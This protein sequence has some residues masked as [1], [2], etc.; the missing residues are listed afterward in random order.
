MPLVRI[1]VEPEVVVIVDSVAVT[2]VASE[3]SSTE[4]KLLEDVPNLDNSQSY[5]Y[6][7]P[8]LEL[9]TI[10]STE[11]INE[12]LS[13][14]SVQ[15]DSLGFEMLTRDNVQTT[16]VTPASV[17]SEETIQKW[18][19]DIEPERIVVEDSEAF[20]VSELGD[21]EESVKSQSQ[22]EEAETSVKLGFSSNTKGIS[23]Q[24]QKRRETL[25]KSKDRELRKCRAVSQGSGRNSRSG[26]SVRTSKSTKAGHKT[27]SLRSRNIDFQY[28]RPEQLS[29]REQLSE[30]DESAAL[31]EINSSPV[32]TVF[33][34]DS[35]RSGDVVTL[36]MGNENMET[37]GD[38]ATTVEVTPNTL[39]SNL[40]P[41]ADEFR[42]LTVELEAARDKAPLAT[43]IVTL[44]F[45]EIAGDS[46][47]ELARTVGAE[48]ARTSIPQLQSFFDT[49][50]N[51][52]TIKTH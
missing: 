17:D 43:E 33:G 37:Q 32:S 52:F 22:T 1:P 45:D 4:L 5:V 21:L 25:R 47:G 46:S 18:L 12:L 44:G 42:V 34:S 35:D 9:R 3:N 27:L 50:K 8:N 19:H 41:E 24:M 13:I 51:F 39:G 29:T 14:G 16:V 31:V 48:E 2:E 23:S 49:V 10:D 20:N 7:S 6:S 38:V 36:D 26:R 28:R 40:N 15:S 11:E 30:I